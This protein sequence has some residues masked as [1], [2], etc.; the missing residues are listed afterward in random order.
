MDA[1]WRQE[2]Q[3]EKNLGAKWQKL[4]RKK[5]ESEEVKIGRIL[6]ARMPKGQEFG[7]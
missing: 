3:K 5:L 4:E 1:S 2:C 6:G 7:S